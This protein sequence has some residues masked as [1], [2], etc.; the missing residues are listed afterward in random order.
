[1]SIQGTAELLW[2]MSQGSLARISHINSMY[3]N[4]FFSYSLRNLICY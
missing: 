2:G 4:K 1:M 3:E